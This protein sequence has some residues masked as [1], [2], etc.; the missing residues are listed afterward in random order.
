MQGAAALSS[1]STPEASI[2]PEQQSV[3][4]LVPEIMPQ[5]TPPHELQASVQQASPSA[6]PGRPL[7]QVDG[8]T[9]GS[10]REIQYDAK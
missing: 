6:T 9:S 1:H 4:P 2:T 8:L 5:F 10:N 3:A 7:G